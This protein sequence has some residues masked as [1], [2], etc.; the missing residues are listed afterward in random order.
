MTPPKLPYVNSYR[1]RHGRIRHYFRRGGKR[2]RLPGHPGSAAFE[3][4][5]QKA[6]QAFEDGKLGPAP[7]ESRT[8]AG[9]MDDLIAR[10]LASRAYRDLAPTTRT[11]YRRVIDRIR[12]DHGDRA[13]AAVTPD[14]VTRLV[15]A[16]ME[17]SGPEAAI[18]LLKILRILFTRAVEDG[19]LSHNPARDVKRPRSG[20]RGYHT[21]TEDEISQFEAQWPRH[22]RQRLALDLLLYTACRRG[23]LVKLGPQHIRDGRLKM[24]QGKTGAVIDIPIHPRLAE[25]L[26]AHPLDALAFLIT[27][28]GRPFTV[29]GFGNFFG[30]ACRAADLDG[31]SAHGLRKAAC[32]RLAEAGC[33]PHQ[34]M[35]VSGHKSLQEVQR[36]CREAGQVDLADQAFARLNEKLA[37]TNRSERL[38]TFPSKALK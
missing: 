22:T 24:S 26:S 20:S 10:Y 2:V 4:A 27:A 23:D 7:G 3:T 12:T 34:I 31:C 35:A 33:S 37:L 38:V 28:Q 30:D 14:A 1:D 15:R 32:R 19:M 18:T 11:V 17:A 16:K 8:T 9:S 25:T 6:M 5:W 29:N 36:Y 13:V 21:W